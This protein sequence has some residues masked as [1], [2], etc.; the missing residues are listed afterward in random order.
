[1]K[2]ILLTALALVTVAVVSITGTIAFL[3]DEKS[4]VNV[5]TT[6]NVYIEQHEYQRAT[7]TDGTFKTDTIDGVTSYVL[8]AFKQA[9]PLLPATTLDAN[10]NPYNYGAGDY[11]STIVRMTQVGSYGGMNVFSNKNAVD[12][13]VVVENTGKND[14]YIRTLVAIEVGTANP[15]LITFSH[16]LT[17][18]VNEIGTITIDGNDYYL[19]ELTY[20]GAKHLGGQHEKG[21]LPAGDTAYPSLSQVYI[22]AEATNEDMVKLDDN[23]NGTLDIFV[24]SQAVQVAGFADAETALN[25]GF[26]DITA[27]NHPWSDVAPAIPAV[28][29]WEGVNYIT[30]GDTTTVNSAGGNTF[31]RNIVSD[32]VSTV[33]NVVVEEGITRLNNRALCKA[34]T[35]TSV[36]LP[37]SLTYIDEGV[38]QQSGFVEIEI[39]ENVVYIGKQAMGACGSLE[40]IVINAKD[41]TIANYVAR[42]C[43]N[44]KEV[45]IN[46]DSVTFE[47]G[48]MYFTNKENADASGITFYVKNQAIADTLY[49]AFSTSHSYGLLIKNVNG[50]VYYNTLK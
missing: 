34:P 28:Y 2:K 42:A 18:E 38:F 33:S 15:D 16:H 17:W 36:E 37:D 8:E 44:L 47:S 20:T 29:S 39:P 4:D 35:I 5:M 14:A 22:K 50:T 7:N 6:G 3:Q 12:K 45:Y 10:G 40:K 48:S 41:V 19:Y 32:G 43:A 30:E 23:G 31:Y 27:T 46:S 21:I 25:A 1:M 11:D 13:F 24:V 9:K 49:N 26:G